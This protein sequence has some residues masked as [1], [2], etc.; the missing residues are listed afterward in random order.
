MHV[1]VKCVK[2]KIKAT[3]SSIVFVQLYIAHNTPIVHNI[4]S[5]V[6]AVKAVNLLHSMYYNIHVI[7]VRIS[8]VHS[9]P[10]SII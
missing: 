9:I 5:E 6:K 2:Y 7:R 8:M 4:Q 3:R 10:R 1:H